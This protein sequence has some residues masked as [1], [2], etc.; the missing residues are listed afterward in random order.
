MFSVWPNKS[1][2]AEEGRLGEH[3]WKRSGLNG[4]SDAPVFISLQRFHQINQQKRT[5]V[6]PASPGMTDTFKELD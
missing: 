5:V 6:L 2:R 3:T 1:D 4:P